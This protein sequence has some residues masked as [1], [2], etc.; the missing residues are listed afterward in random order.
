M[1][2]RWQG[3]AC[4]CCEYKGM[5]YLAKL[6]DL[7]GKVFGEWTVIK[8]DEFAIGR[9]VRWI[10]R[11][12]CGE[13]RSVLGTSLNRGISESC[14]H[15]LRKYPPIKPG[16]VFTYLTVIEEDTPFICNDNHK[17]RRWKCKCKCGNIVS[18]VDADLKSGNT[19]SCG[20]FNLERIRETED[21]VGQKYGRL[22]VVERA[23]NHVA[24]SGVESI[25]WKCVCECGNETVVNSRD[26]KTGNTKSCGCLKADWIK[27][28]TKHGMHDSRLYHVWEGIKN[29]CCN[30]NSGMYKNYG[31]RG[32]KICKEWAEDFLSFY[33]WAMSNGYDE[34]ASFGECTLDRIDNNG[35]YSPENCRFVSVKEQARN[36]RRNKMVSYNNETK[37]LSE[38]CEEFNLNYKRTLYRINKG[39]SLKEIIDSNECI[40]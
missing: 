38:W 6:I 27:E 39:L 28:N 25:A 22:T 24:K 5:N 19:K 26:L 31:A 8:R 29:R 33:S 13:T 30:E 12:S 32:I 2:L 11:C 36:T 35:D 18:V 23:P 9:S 3:G 21:L 14:G 7:T 10:C 15:A 40:A 1:W 17:K 4:V 37:C 16:D 34:S 20:C